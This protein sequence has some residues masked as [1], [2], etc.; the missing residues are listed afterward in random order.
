MLLHLGCPR[1]ACSSLGNSWLKTVHHVK[2][3]FGVSSDSYTSTESTPLFGPGQGSTP[4]PFLW[5]L[6]FILIA[7]LVQDL[8]SLNMSNPTGDITL[9]NQGDAFVDDSYLATASMATENVVSDTV[10]NLS[11]LSQTWERG[12][13][14]TGGAINL[15]KSFWILM[16][17][18]WHRRNA[19]LL[20][21]SLHGNKLQLTAGYE[22]NNPVEVPLLSPY[23][24]Y[25]TLGAYISPSG[26]VHQAYCILRAHSV[27]YATRI[28]ASNINRE[29]ALWSYLLYL[30]P[31]L[32]FPL[33]AMTFTELQC[34]RI[35]SPAINALLQKLHLNRKTARS[36]IH[37]PTLYGGMDL[38]HLFTSQGF[39]QLKFLLGHLRAQDKTNKLLL[40]GHGYVQLSVGISRNFL[41]E[42]YSTYHHWVCPSWF[43]SLW[44][45]MDKLQLQVTIKKA[46]IPPTADT[47]NVN[48]M[49]YF[50]S[51]GLSRKS[52]Q[53]VNR[54]RIY[55]QVLP[56]S[57]IVS[58]DGRTLIRPV[59]MGK[60]LIDR[61][62]TL[63]WPEQGRPPPTDWQVWRSSLQPL[64]QGDSLN[65][66]LDMAICPS[67]QDYFWFMD[68]SYTLYN[69]NDSNWTQ[70]L[71]SSTRPQRKPNQRYARSNGSACSMPA[72][73]LFPASVTEISSSI[74]EAVTSNDP[75]LTVPPP[76]SQ[77][78]LPSLQLHDLQL[79][80]NPFY[81][82]L[83]GDLSLSS[84][85]MT[86][87]LDSLGQGLLLAC[88]D[89]SYD[90]ITN[91]A[92][93]GM[94]FGTEQIPVL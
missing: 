79:A 10:E 67:H 1:S 47:S 15:H 30:L 84:I 87:L 49:N 41:N 73:I 53:S 31:K 82:Y 63:V 70:Y 42:S 94:V 71:P 78:T 40:I 43:T 28:Q 13:F 88:S 58:A 14:S 85:Q 20:P 33:M 69:Q 39:H 18:K 19:L 56:L 11:L 65:E 34:N 6:C 80:T 27:E 74:L 9:S 36:I 22:T 72:A 54:C 23:D 89:G 7:Q 17:W 61:R 60:K 59:L 50:V 83:L 44:Y 38:P 52:L 93:Y 4:G 92:A 5:L 35:Q 90:P 29:A 86:Q 16:S 25:R 81:S 37:G 91:M 46:W 55:L 21:P 75:V 3:Q 24:S 62:S 2:T 45:F 64:A 68:S 26:G 12:L 76:E 57:D 77:V 8:P 32:T 66:P 51:Q 48:L